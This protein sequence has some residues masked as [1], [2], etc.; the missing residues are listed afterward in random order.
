ML[1][2]HTGRISWTRRCALNLAAVG[3]ST[4]LFSGL[5]GVGGGFVIVPGLGLS[6]NISMHATTATSL[7]VIALVSS[8]SAITMEIQGVTINESGWWFVIAAGVW[9]FVGRQLT[10]YITPIFVQWSLA[11]LMLTTAILFVVKI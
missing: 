8:I 9:T 3:A 7:M 5:Y 6:T 2:Q 1:N 11:F 10:R 4:G